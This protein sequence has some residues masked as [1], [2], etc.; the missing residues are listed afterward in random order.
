MEL[1]LKKK[2]VNFS[3]WHGEEKGRT[4]INSNTKNCSNKVK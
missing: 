4:E 1:L 3:I 2:K